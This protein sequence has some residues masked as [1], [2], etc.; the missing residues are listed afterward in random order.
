MN[1]QI[2]SEQLKELDEHIFNNEKLEY[3]QL[4][5][6]LFNCS[7]LEAQESLTNR[8]KELRSNYSKQFTL[9]DSEY[10]K[11]FYS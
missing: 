3:L 6:E 11:S 8:Y 2:K 7:L 5:R 9:S 10:W 4:Y 1:S